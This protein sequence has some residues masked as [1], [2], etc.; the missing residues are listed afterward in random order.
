MLG[1][2]VIASA[3]AAC[4]DGATCCARPV[5]ATAAPSSDRGDH[6]L[7]IVED[8]HASDQIIGHPHVPY[9]NE[10]ARTYGTATRLDAGYPMPAAGRLPATDQR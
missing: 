3:I 5:P 7:L 10:P 9:L 6:V 8:N 2:A 1:F 4:S